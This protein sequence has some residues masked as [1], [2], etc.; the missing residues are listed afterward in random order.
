MCNASF[1]P[2]M[3]W[4]ICISFPTWIRVRL[5]F[6]IILELCL[7]YYLNLK[8]PCI[9]TTLEDLS[10]FMVDSSARTLSSMF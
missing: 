10:L 8:S 7:I 2:A 4:A 9:M 6:E 5:R 3:N 1:T